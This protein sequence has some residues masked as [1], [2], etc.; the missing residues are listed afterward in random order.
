MA[1]SRGLVSTRRR[2]GRS[3]FLGFAARG[4]RGGVAWGRFARVGRVAG[5]RRLVSTRRRSGRSGFL[6]FAA[7]GARGGVA[8][9]RFA[10]VGQTSEILAARLHAAARRSQ[11]VA[12]ALLPLAGAAAWRGVGPPFG[13]IRTSAPR[14]FAS[15]NGFR[16]HG[17]SRPAR[18]R[19]GPAI[20][21]GCPSTDRP[22]SPI[23]RSSRGI[24]WRSGSVTGPGF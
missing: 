22:R 2:N 14:T 24:V 20:W 6:G 5:S 8:G 19:R 15:T 13:I 18:R 21:A 17:F 16:W 10:P 23:V 1:R 11:R 3:G 4:G 9:G 7:R 12:P